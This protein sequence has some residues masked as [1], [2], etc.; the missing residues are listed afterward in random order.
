MSPHDA[1]VAK[2]RTPVS[3]RIQSTGKREQKRAGGTHRKTKAELIKEL[4]AELNKLFSCGVS[5]DA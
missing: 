1:F 3:L 4:E 5:P 2:L